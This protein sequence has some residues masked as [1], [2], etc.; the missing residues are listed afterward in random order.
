MGMKRGEKMPKVLDE[1]IS[2]DMINLK[3]AKKLANF[4]NLCVSEAL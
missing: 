2:C 4:K 1:S 3:M